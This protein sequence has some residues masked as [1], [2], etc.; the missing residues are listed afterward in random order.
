ML[1]NYLVLCL[2]M[3]LL[4]LSACSGAKEIHINAECGIVMNNIFN[5]INTEDDCRVQCRNQCQAHDLGLASFTFNHDE[6]NG[7]NSCDCVCR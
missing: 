6:S 2:L 4:S 5:K 7:C 3:V 1:R